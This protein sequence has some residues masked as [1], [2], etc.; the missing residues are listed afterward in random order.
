MTAG[1]ETPKLRGDVLYTYPNPCAHGGHSHPM[2]RANPG[3]DLGL[4]SHNLTGHISTHR[5]FLSS[6]SLQLSGSVQK[7]PLTQGWLQTLWFG[8]QHIVLCFLMTLHTP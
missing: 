3:G 7:D 4:D 2:L 1:E 8:V 6:V 5:S